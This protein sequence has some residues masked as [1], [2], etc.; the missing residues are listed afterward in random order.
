MLLD[1]DSFQREGALLL[2]GALSVIGVETY[3][4]L[5]GATDQGAGQRL[6]QPQPALLD[7]IMAS[8]GLCSIASKLEGEPLRPVRLLLFDKSESVNWAVD[9]HQDRVLPLAREYSQPGFDCWTSKSGVPHVEPPSSLSERMVTLRVHLDDSGP[10]NAPLK[11][12]PGSHKMGRLPVEAVAREVRR[13]RPVVHT[14]HTGDVLALKTL[15]VH[16][17]ERAKEPQRRRV[18]HIDFAPPDVLPEGLDWSFSLPN[19]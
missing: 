6:A 3:R 15:I 19:N 17:S 9:W 14:A 7:A 5:L 1:R 2:E 10:T 4:K 11:T 13:I 16:A 12:L 18:L 8:G